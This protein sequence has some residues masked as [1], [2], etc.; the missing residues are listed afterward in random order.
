MCHVTYLPVPELPLCYCPVL[1]PLQELIQR[2]VTLTEQ[3]WVLDVIIRGE[4][5]RN[6]ERR[7]EKGKKEEDEKREKVEEGRM[8]SERGGGMEEGEGKLYVPGWCFSE[9]RT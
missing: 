4:G 1:L 9:R 5:R 7:R 2:V 3:S 8:E 6:E